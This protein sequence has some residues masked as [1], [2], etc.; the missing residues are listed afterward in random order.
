MAGRRLQY[1]SKHMGYLAPDWETFIS[2]RLCLP[3]PQEAA[4]KAGT[5]QRVIHISGP[6]GIGLRTGLHLALYRAP[7]ALIVGDNVD[8]SKRL[9]QEAVM[10]GKGVMWVAEVSEDDP[11]R[12]FAANVV[13]A[14]CGQDG[15]LVTGVIISRGIHTRATVSALLQDVSPSVLEMHWS[16]TPGP[17]SDLHLAKKVLK[18]WQG[19]R[20]MTIVEEE[21]LAR[22]GLFYT[23]SNVSD[24]HRLFSHHGTVKSMG[25]LSQWMAHCKSWQETRMQET[26]F[27]AF[28]MQEGERERRIKAIYWA[29]LRQM[30]EANPWLRSR[31]PDELSL[32][33]A[34][35][36]WE[37]CVAPLD[38]RAA[39]T[40]A[41]AATPATEDEVVAAVEFLCDTG[42]LVRG[43]CGKQF[44]DTL[45][46][47]SMASLMIE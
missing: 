24:L 45:F 34:C 39:V 8:K 43:E 20:H 2:R 26:L 23:G 6:S 17:P 41:R 10:G 37:T 19:R 13:H 7:N 12:A 11:G 30:G 38:A 22:V 46:P 40:A 15:R 27:L 44:P 16:T 36:S 5:P 1:M 31:H 42:L 32:A 35:T 14:M 3:W 47:S 9:V 4:A 28:G 25:T 21:M 29:L 33:V 18:Y